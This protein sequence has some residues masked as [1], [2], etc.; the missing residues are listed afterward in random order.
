MQNSKLQFTIQN[1]L[2]KLPSILTFRFELLISKKGFS[3]IELMVAITIVSV[4][5]AIGLVIYSSAQKGARVQKRVEDLKAIKTSLEVYKASTGVYPINLTGGCIDTTLTAIVP[6]YMP[7]LP[8]DPRGSVN[9]YHYR[10]DAIGNEYKIRTNITD[11]DMV[12]ADFNRQPTMIDPNRDGG[13]DNC[14]SDASATTPVITAW[15]FYTA[16]ACAY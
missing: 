12:S 11:G 14:R 10:S 2:K 9:C 6:N 4:L 13:T 16:G 3:L 8:V 5:S 7:N 1:F 15:A